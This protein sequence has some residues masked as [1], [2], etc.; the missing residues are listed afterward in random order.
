MEEWGNDGETE[1]WG[2]GLDRGAA[3]E[4]S[5]LSEAANSLF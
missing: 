1:G 4:I 5:W 3:L 2:G